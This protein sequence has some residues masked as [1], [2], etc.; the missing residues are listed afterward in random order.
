[1]KS[2]IYYE[3]FKIT[4]NQIKSHNKS[5]TPNQKENVKD[6]SFIPKQWDFGPKCN[7]IHN[8]TKRVT[9]LPFSD[10]WVFDLSD[11]MIL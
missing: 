2:L 11:Q 4:T 8:E 9:T 5:Q 10:K 7:K 6:I 1:M 3:L